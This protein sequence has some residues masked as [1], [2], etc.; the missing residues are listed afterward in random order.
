MKRLCFIEME[1]VLSHFGSYVPD[2]KKVELFLKKLSVFCKKNKVELFL[3]SGHHESVASKKMLEHKFHAFFD[4]EHFLFV[5]ENYISKKDEVDRKLHQDALEKDP[6]FVD[7]YFKQVMIQKI[8]AEK[9]FSPKDALLL[10]DD[11]WVDGYYNIRFS[12]IDFA[13]F[14]GNILERGKPAKKIDG[15]A[16]FTLDFSSVKK[17]LENFPVVDNSFLDRFVFEEMKKVLVGESVQNAIRESAIRHMN[18]Q[19]N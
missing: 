13:I 6:H 9:K 7:T 14:E 12:K 16:Y 3:V 1:G 4:E 10:S 11:L 18:Q 17:L 5:D 19:N 2:K 8:L 15:L